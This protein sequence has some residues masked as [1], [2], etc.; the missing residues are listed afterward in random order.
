M[1]TPFDILIEHTGLRLYI[2]EDP[3]PFSTKDPL[4]MLSILVA[5]TGATFEGGPVLTQTE[6][7][8]IDSY[9]EK[10]CLYPR[11]SGRHVEVKSTNSHLIFYV[12]NINIYKLDKTV[13]ITQDD[14][15]IKPILAVMGSNGLDYANTVYRFNE[16][17]KKITA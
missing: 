10:Q 8:E 17:G 7:K 15:W 3:T 5:A 4:H 6:L 2:S 13:L 12:D 14:W 9:L 1:R 11:A 16:D